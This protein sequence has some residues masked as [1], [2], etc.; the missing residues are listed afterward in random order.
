LAARDPAG[1]LAGLIMEVLAMRRPA[2]FCLLLGLF[3]ACPGGTSDTSSGGSTSSDETTGDA[4]TGTPP[5][6]TTT[7]TPTTGGMTTG[8]PETTTTVDPDTSGTSSTTDGGPV[9]GNGIEEGDEVCD[10]GNG[11]DTDLCTNACKFAFCGDGIVGPT[12]DCDDANS[13]NTDDCVETCKFQECGDGYLGA[14]ETCDDGNNNDG[15]AC[16]N[17]CA[18]AGCGDGVKGPMEECDDMNDNDAD[19][20]PSNC[21]NATCGDKFVQTE[22]FDPDADPPE[23]A[24]ECDDGNDQNADACTNKCTIA[25]CGDKIAQVG[26]EECDDG[27]MIDSDKC[28]NM[29]LLATCT[30]GAK[31]DTETDVDCGGILCDKCADGLACKVASD[32]ASNKCTASVCA[33]LTLTGVNCAVANV[34][35]AQAYGVINNNCSCHV[36]GAS[37]GLAMPDMDAFH[38]NTVGVDASGAVMMN[39]ITANN[40]DAS[41][42]LYKIYNQHTNVLNGGG[43]SMPQGQPALTTANRCL[44]VNWV[45]SGAP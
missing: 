43:T 44:L 12:E 28:T 31:N 18:P 35:R 2:S 5:P 9:C 16:T 10:D 34:T 8:D 20:C 6:T 37:G 26:V 11:I 33:P 25:K 36:L 45:K 7:M 21:K 29:C 1:I 17:A 24:E 39:R 14:D 19:A 38:A 30:D 32:C 41:Y 22:G 42:L 15:D 3:A 4:S 40:I 13:D 23:V 27:N